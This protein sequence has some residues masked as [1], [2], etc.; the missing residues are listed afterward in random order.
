MDIK[1][2]IALL[3]QLSLVLTIASVGLRARWSDVLSVAR[4]SSRVL[5]AVIAVNVIV[6]S[7]ATVAMLILPVEPMVKVGVLAMAIAPLAP[8]VPDKMLRVGASSS[9]TVGIYVALMLL[10][11]AVVPISL[12]LLRFVF[13]GTAE[14]SVPDLASVVLFAGLAPLGLGLAI[15][16]LMSRY[17]A[18]LARVTSLLGGLA[19]IPLVAIV[20]IYAG[21]DI[22]ALTGDGV[23][24]AIILIVI[25]GLAAG[26]WLGG[27]ERNNRYALAIAAATRHPGIASL[28]VDSNFEDRKPMLAVI[29]FLLI[30][31]L[32]SAIYE[33]WT[34]SAGGTRA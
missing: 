2:T 31:V 13:N 28:I 24:L 26:H 15:A 16:T 20:L 6:P 18:G 21:A 14:I 33:R 34:R 25:S 27:P 4:E 7:V 10:A 19:L 3:A 23:V 17:A 5:R 32:V 8:L 1:S 11:I 30:S 9:Y 12:A 22:I 29:L